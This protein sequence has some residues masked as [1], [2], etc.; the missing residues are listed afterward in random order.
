MGMH[1][2]KITEESMNKYGTDIHQRNIDIFN[3][4]EK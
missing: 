2:T 4:L 3:S 1:L